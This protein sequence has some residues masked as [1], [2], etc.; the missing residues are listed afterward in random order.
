MNV[1]PCDGSVMQ[2]DRCSHLNISIEVNV[3]VVNSFEVNV[4]VVREKEVRVFSSL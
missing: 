4:V 2:S 3:I 1:H